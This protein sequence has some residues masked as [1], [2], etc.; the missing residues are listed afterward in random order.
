MCK[1]TRKSVFRYISKSEICSKIR[2]EALRFPAESFIARPSRKWRFTP[3][4]IRIRRRDRRCPRSSL[5]TIYPAAKYTKNFVV[6]TTVSTCRRL[7]SGYTMWIRKR[8]YRIL[9]DGIFLPTTQVH[10]AE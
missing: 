7:L 2:R 4:L 9:L 10:V 6:F 1:A 8:T 5:I 3:A